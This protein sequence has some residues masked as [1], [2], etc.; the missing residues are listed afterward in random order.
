[1]SPLQVA[2][3]HGCVGLFHEGANLLHLGL[4]ILVERASGGVL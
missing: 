4:L 1:M 2:G 3:F